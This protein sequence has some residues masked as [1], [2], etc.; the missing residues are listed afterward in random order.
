MALTSAT[1]VIR[2]TLKTF[3]PVAIPSVTMAITLAIHKSDHSICHNKYISCHTYG[4]SICCIG[5]N[6]SLYKCGNSI[7][8][9]GNNISQFTLWLYHLPQ[10]KNISNHFKCG[11]HLPQTNKSGYSICHNG[12]KHQPYHNHM[13]NNICQQH[14]VVANQ[15]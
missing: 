7:H 6:I 12:K 11:F 3:Q 8:H 9:Y 13:A 2:S 5:C 10:S 14:P 1:K 4:C 15:L